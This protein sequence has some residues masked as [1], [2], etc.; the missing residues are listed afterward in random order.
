LFAA[1]EATGGV[2]GAN[3]LSGNAFTEMILWGH[4]SGRFAAEYAKGTGEISID[5][6]QLEAKRLEVFAPLERDDGLSQV[7]VRKKLQQVAWEKAG[8]I[9]DKTSIEEALTEFARMR[10]EDLSRVCVK[11]KDRI[12]NR[13]WIQAYE[14]NSMLT[15]LEMVCRTSL[16][17]T[18][19]RGALYRR[20]YP[21]TDNVNWLKNQIVKKTD[22]G[23]QIWSEPV[24]IT[25]LDPPKKIM[26]YGQTE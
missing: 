18:E 17:R 11:N 3:R 26:K 9:R 10:E 5:L 23:M 8:V 15:I 16:N 24:V 20:D 22:E 2:H 6:D 13:E 21:E 1:G 19:S 25:K 4:R 14:L 12:Y 7:D